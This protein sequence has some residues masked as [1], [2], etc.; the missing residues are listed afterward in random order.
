MHIAVSINLCIWSGCFQ[1]PTWGVSPLRTLLCGTDSKSITL[2]TVVLLRI[3]DPQANGYKPNRDALPVGPIQ[4]IYLVFNQY[5][6]ASCLAQA[7]DP[8][9][10]ASNIEKLP[11]PSYICRFPL[12]AI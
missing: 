11:L 1:A 7:P 3:L 5:M 9:L 6:A 8:S 4:L 2:G 12:P 10:F